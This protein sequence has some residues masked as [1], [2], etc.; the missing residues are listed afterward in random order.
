MWL[1]LRAKFLFVCPFKG[2]FLQSFHMKKSP[3]ILFPNIAIATTHLSQKN[4]AENIYQAQSNIVYIFVS[5]TTSN[6]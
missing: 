2:H 3:K 4:C 6:I 5:N 1:L